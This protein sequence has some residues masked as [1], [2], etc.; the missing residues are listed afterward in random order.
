MLCWG[1]TPALRQEGYQQGSQEFITALESRLTGAGEEDEDEEEEEEE[2]EG[3]EE[4]E[5]L[6]SGVFII[7]RNL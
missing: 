5:G 6:R 2:E 4:E 1:Y 7:E 3:S